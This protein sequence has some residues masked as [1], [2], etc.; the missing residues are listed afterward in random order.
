[1]SSELETI[2]AKDANEP[3]EIEPVKLDF[4]T[5]LEPSPEKPESK[6]YQV[7]EPVARSRRGVKLN[8]MGFLKSTPRINLV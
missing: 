5:M 4:N 1:M 3:I 6:E 7:K 8:Y 2:F